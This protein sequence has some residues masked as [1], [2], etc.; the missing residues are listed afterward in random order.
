VAVAVAVE[1]L[2]MCNPLLLDYLEALA[3][4]VVKEAQTGVL[5]HQDKEILEGEETMTY[6]LVLMEALVAEVEPAKLDSERG[7]MM[8]ELHIQNHKEEKVEM[9]L[10]TLLVLQ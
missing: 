3:E 4:V 5:E 6:V 7:Q 9:E 10:R 8:Q 1:T 2:I